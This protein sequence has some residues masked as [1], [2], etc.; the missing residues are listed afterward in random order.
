[1]VGDGV[2]PSIFFNNDDSAVLE[3]EVLKYDLER[4]LENY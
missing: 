1:M 4:E 2:K 3:V